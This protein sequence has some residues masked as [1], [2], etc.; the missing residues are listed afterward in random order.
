M[1]DV[2]LKPLDTNA[3]FVVL[4]EWVIAEGRRVAQGETICHVET[5]KTVV[6]VSAPS[7][8]VLRHCARVGQRLAVGTVLA[9][10]SLADEPSAATVPK[11]TPDAGNS[12]SERVSR[13]AQQLITQHGLDIS[14]F[15]ARGFISAADVQQLLEQ[16]ERERQITTGGIFPLLE[17]VDI[18]GVTFPEG[19]GELTEGSLSPEFLARL[20]ANPAAFRDLPENER[21]ELLRKHGA[22]IGRGARLGERTFICAPQIVLGDGASIEAGSDVWCAERFIMG[23]LARFGPRL[24]LRCQQAVVGAAVWAEYDI[25]IGGGG[26]RDPWAVI[27]IGDNCYLGAELFINTCRPVL[28]GRNAF[29]TNRATLLTH[30]IGHSYIHG[31]EN[32]FAAVVLEDLTQVG[33]NTV[34]YA[35]AR[36]GRGAVVGSNGYVIDPIPPGKLALGVPARVVGDA[37]QVLSL[38]RQEGRAKEMLNDLYK[39]LAAKGYES[40]DT[41]K[42]INQ[43]F[44]FK[45][46][47]K[48][49]GLVLQ[50]E[51]SISVLPKG[52]RWIVWTLN[53][54]QTE[55]DEGIVVID[56]L[57]PHIVGTGDALWTDTICEYLRKR[58]LKVHT[59][60]WR[61]QGGLFDVVEKSSNASL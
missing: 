51:V 4:V 21:L 7:A 15:P 26:H 55:P 43:A 40:T 9:T 29:V 32:K 56:L 2:V 22:S 49:L 37:Q 42:S 18:S 11:V 5:S 25:I 16:L 57:T 20:K 1:T 33:I 59:K 41:A 47:G 31:H 52:V 8:G 6:E 50:N 17:G 54:F 27:V 3:D 12:P 46:A 58:G 19:S 14:H 36:I 10:I 23:P 60:P 13:K 45:H 61:Y 30:N 24:N 44:T 39:L 35:G 48:E 53:P 34:V 28:I 38:Q